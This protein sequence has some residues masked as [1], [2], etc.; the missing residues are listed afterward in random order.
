MEREHTAIEA[1]PWRLDDTKA[2]HHKAGLLPA[3]QKKYDAFTQHVAGGMNPFEAAQHAGVKD[4]KHLGN[5]QYQGKLGDK[6]RF[7]TFHEEHTHPET[8]VVH[9]VVRIHQVGGHTK[10]KK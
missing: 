10:A 7:T 9:P 2:T 3:E 1:V 4:Y 5:G 8:G 6:Q